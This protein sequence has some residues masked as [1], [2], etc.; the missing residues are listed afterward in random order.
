MTRLYVA[1]ASMAAFLASILAA[2]AKGRKDRETQIRAEAAR[3]NEETTRA[4]NQ[5]ARAA[6]RDGAAERLRDG[7]F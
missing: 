7:R 6:E 2:W 1:L 4:G 3:A 5:A